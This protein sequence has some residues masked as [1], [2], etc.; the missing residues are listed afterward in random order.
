M[1]LNRGYKTD[2]IVVL[3]VTS[4]KNTCYNQYLL[5]FYLSVTKILDWLTNRRLIRR[6]ARVLLVKVVEILDLT[7]DSC[8]KSLLQNYTK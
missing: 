4:T 8:K 5:F 6:I 7:N 1:P 3:L 2:K